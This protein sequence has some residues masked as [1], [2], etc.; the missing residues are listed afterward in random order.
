MARITCFPDRKEVDV[1]DG[2]TILE[3]T[4]RANIAHAHACGG[5]ARCSTCRVWVL[6]GLE[7]CVAR[8]D[9]ERSLTDRLGL[10]PEVR[11]ACQT[12]IAGD[13]KLRR[14]VLDE[15]DLEI[16]SQLSRK[17]LGRC[18][19]AKRN[20]NGRIQGQYSTDS[21]GQLDRRHRADRSDLSGLSLH[22]FRTNR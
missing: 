7:N 22:T 13:V 9:R 21:P 16:T 1:R 12:R 17:R 4:L 10:G 14:L 19:E 3:A 18:G 20:S 11:L 8:S 6:E 2:D 15:T 5:H